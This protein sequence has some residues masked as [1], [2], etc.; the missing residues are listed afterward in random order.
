MKEPPGYWVMKN[1][2]YFEKMEPNWVDFKHF[3]MCLVLD[4][5]SRLG[6][7]WETPFHCSLYPLWGNAPSSDSVLN[8]GISLDCFL[9]NGNRKW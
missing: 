5:I 4:V 7:G 8:M 2:G 6:W 9:G 3:P 1:N